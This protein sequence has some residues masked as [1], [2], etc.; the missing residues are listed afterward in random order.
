MTRDD[1]MREMKGRLVQAY[2][3]RLHGLVLYGSEA[4]GEAEPESDLDV[5]VLLGDEVHEPDDSWR[6]IRALYPLMLEW[7]R[8]IHAEPV[9]LRSYEAQE[10]PLYRNARREGRQA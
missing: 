1:M 7:E 6:C 5:L 8:P 9:D 10:F 2:G 3:A 4:R